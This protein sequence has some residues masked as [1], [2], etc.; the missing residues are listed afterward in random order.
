M[1]KLCVF[2][3]LRVL[4]SLVLSSFGLA[5][6]ILC[7]FCSDHFRKKVL[8]ERPKNTSASYFCQNIHISC[9]PIFWMDVCLFCGYFVCFCKCYMCLSVV[10]SCVDNLPGRRASLTEGKGGG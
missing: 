7:S 8:A 5:Q 9:F 4:Q 2:N 10:I 6:P 1:R 3:T